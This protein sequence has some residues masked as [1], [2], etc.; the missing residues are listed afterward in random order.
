MSVNCFFGKTGSGKSHKAIQKMGEYKKRI[1]FDVTPSKT[2]NEKKLKELNCNGEFL[3][4][5][6]YSQRS[7]E[8]LIVKMVEKDNFTLVFR[9]SSELDIYTIGE[10]VC[11]FSMRY[12]NYFDEN[13]KE[14]IVL[15]L[16]ELDKYV[17]TSKQSFISR[18]IGMGR[19]SHLDLFCVSQV[20]SQ[21]PKVIRDNALKEYFFTLG[22]NEYYERKLGQEIS[23]ILDKNSIAE[24]NY[25]FKNDSDITLMNLNDKSIP[26][27]KTIKR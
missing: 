13:Y 10:L 22:M 25:F 16:D 9:P 8:E 14:I 27:N 21:M 6:N 11:S 5:N 7:L 23:S 15:V 12:G 18:A 17:S 2:F 19:H 3:E 1:V 20:P 24:F 26:F 4:H